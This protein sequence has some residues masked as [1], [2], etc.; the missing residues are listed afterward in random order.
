MTTPEPY[1]YAAGLS[2]LGQAIQAGD[3]VYAGDVPMAA[4]SE[5]DRLRMLAYP[6]YLAER[7]RQRDSDARL[8]VRYTIP[9]WAS[10][11]A[12]ALPGHPFNLTPAGRTYRRQP[13]PETCDDSRA[14]HWEAL[15]DAHLREL[16]QIVPKIDA[17]V[18]RASD[19]TREEGFRAVLRLALRSPSQIQ[20]ALREAAPGIE[21]MDEPLRF[22]GAE[23]RSCGAIRGATS[24]EADWDRAQFHCEECGNVQEA[25][26][27]EQ[28]YWM[29]DDLQAAAI[30]AAFRPAVVLLR[31]GSRWEMREAI[32]D[33]LLLLA[34]GD[35]EQVPT[36]LIAPSVDSEVGGTPLRDLIDLAK[37]W[38]ESVAELP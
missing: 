21:I 14:L 6:G 15:F 9:D 37:D 28:H 1:R 27:R 4:M 13:D 19:L 18:V 23:C 5:G 24:Y 35:S 20:E 3:V 33:S 2:E 26:I 7:L 22:A 29:Q 30:Q 34:I 31:H 32:V 11:E 10:D 8:T 16:T 12:V 25:D 17:G 38:N 36:R